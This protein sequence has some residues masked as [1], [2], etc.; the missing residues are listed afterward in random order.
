MPFY[1]GIGRGCAGCGGSLV[2]VHWLDALPKVRV[3]GGGADCV[4]C[5]AKGRHFAV[6][7]Y[8]FIFQST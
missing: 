6:L 3:C 8:S 7:S 1:A 4:R 2:I 5:E